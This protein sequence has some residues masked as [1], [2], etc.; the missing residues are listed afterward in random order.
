MHRMYARGCWCAALHLADVALPPTRYITCEA[1][2]MGGP[3]EPGDPGAS[4]FRPDKFFIMLLE[5]WKDVE[6][7]ARRLPAD[8]AAAS[9]AH[10][11]VQS[12]LSPTARESQVG[13]TEGRAGGAPLTVDTG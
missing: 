3:P 12:G 11:R 7:E 4:R 8:L 10:S 2:A 5:L 9:P 6:A 13:T 1:D